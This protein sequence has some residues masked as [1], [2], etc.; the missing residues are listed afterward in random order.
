MHEGDQ[1][2][3]FGHF[4]TLGHDGASCA[5]HQQA[6]QYPTQAH[7]WIGAEI[8]N[9][10]T[11]GQNRNGHASHAKHVAANGGGGMGQT[12]EGLNK[13]DARNEVQQGH[14]VHA[15]FTGPPLSW[16]VCLFS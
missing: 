11:R 10:C 1:L 5:P 2:G 8:E 16:Q 6:Q 13:E 3:H 4:H 7:G 15:H 14:E 12:L 9:E